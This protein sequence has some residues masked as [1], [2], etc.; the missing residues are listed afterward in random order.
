MAPKT[1]FSD[2]GAVPVSTDLSELVA[3][4]E[5][6][7]PIRPAIAAALREG[8]DYLARAEQVVR[9]ADAPL[10]EVATG[11]S[12]VPVDPDGLARLAQRWGVA[13]PVGRLRDAIAGSVA[14][15]A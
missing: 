4:R 10:A 8:A 11:L 3:V 9:V 15:P 5:G 1:D 14:D 7:A 12:A 6:S 2:L 13:G